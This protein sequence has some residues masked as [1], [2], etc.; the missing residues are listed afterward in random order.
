MKTHILYI[1]KS[2][3]II[4]NYYNSDDESKY[5]EQKCSEGDS[6]IEKMEFVS[7]IDRFDAINNLRKNKKERNHLFVIKE[8]DD[9]FDDPIWGTL[10]RMYS[11]AKEWSDSNY[12]EYSTILGRLTRYASG[13]PSYDDK[14][15]VESAFG[16][17]AERIVDAIITLE[18]KWFSSAIENF[19]KS[20]YL[21]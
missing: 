17:D 8:K 15:I 7:E 6:N 2:D 1:L 10:A 20:I 3:E 13:Y 21:K 4:N 9:I 11:F 5:L 16:T 19:Y 18:T 12:E 14:I